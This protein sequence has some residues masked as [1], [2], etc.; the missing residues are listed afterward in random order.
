MMWGIS[1]IKERMRLNLCD[2]WWNP[3]EQ[4]AGRTTSFQAQKFPL[5]L[6]LYPPAPA[7]IAPCSLVSQKQRM[8]F[9]QLAEMVCGDRCS[10]ARGTSRQTQARSDSWRQ[11]AQSPA[12]LSLPGCDLSARYVFSYRP[13]C[14]PGHKRNGFAREVFSRFPDMLLIY[15]LNHSG[16]VR[17]L[18]KS[19]YSLV[20][21]EQ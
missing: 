12:M 10:I 20:G 14:P 9:P 3:A 2:G 21:F 16:S 13:A 7:D 4:G 17:C 15:A 6:R 5:P 19:A 18:S 1:L 8:P 11:S